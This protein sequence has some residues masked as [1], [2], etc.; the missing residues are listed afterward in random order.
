MKIVYVID[1]LARKGGA[2]RVIINKMDYMVSH[3]GYTISIITCCQDKDIPNAYPIPNSIKQICL[4]VPFYS[5]YNYSYPYRLWVKHSIHCQ[6]KKALTDAVQTI[7]P[8]ILIGVSYFQAN[9]VTGI[10]CRAKKLI[11]VHEP[12]P[13][14]LSDYELSRGRLS[15]WY[16]KHYRNWYFRKVENQADIVVTL[17]PGDAYEWRRA[18]R[19]QVIPNFTVIPIEKLS[20][21]QAKG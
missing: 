17:T 5:Q 1:T 9:I 6:M 8:D 15:S 4:G 13:F 16:M 19:V 18:K 10:K 12:R 21:G 11:E 14:T 3:F 20:D 7:D 2:E